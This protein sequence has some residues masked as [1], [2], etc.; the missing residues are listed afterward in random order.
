MAKADPRPLA[1][2]ALCRAVADPTAKVLYGSAK[3]AGIFKAGGAS[4]K[5][6]ARLCLDKQWLEPTGA[7]LGKG[8]SK[9]ELHRITPAGIH[10]ALENTEPAALVRSLLPALQDGTQ[11]LHVL[12]EQIGKLAGMIETMFTA[13]GQLARQVQPPDVEQ[14][15]RKLEAEKPAAAPSAEPPAA[16]WMDEVVQMVREQ[17]QRNAFQRLTLPQIYQ[18]LKTSRPALTLGQF[19]DGL[20]TLQEQRRIQLG[21]YTQALATLDD[22]RNALYLDRE[23]KLYVDLP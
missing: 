15:L 11:T 4:E 19:H 10:E 2:D 8:A 6:A 23:V 7:F 12:R 18:R 9:K 1:L 14:V 21:Q 17:K 5:A 16:D 22:A 20:R 13:V 3:V